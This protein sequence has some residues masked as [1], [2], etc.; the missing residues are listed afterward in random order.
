M[1]NKNKIS[2]IYV[3]LACLLL[4]LI[5]VPI[6]GI[7]L[8]LSGLIAFVAYS[9]FIYFCCKFFRKLNPLLILGFTFL[10]WFL[11]NLPVRLFYWKDALIT[12]WEVLMH[13]LGMITGY[14]LWV[15][16]RIWKFVTLLVAT[17]VCVVYAANNIKW[18]DYLSFGKVD[19]EGEQVLEEDFCLRDLNGSELSLNDFKDKYL[20]LDFWSSSCGLCIKSF[21][22]VQSFSEKFSNNQRVSFYSVFCVSAKRCETRQTGFDIVQKRGFSFPLL[23]SEDE[24]YKKFGV[25]CFPTVVI[26]SPDN[27][28]IFRGRLEIAI[29]FI[30]KNINK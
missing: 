15:N 16:K 13:V 18:L 11:L 7:N 24:S 14:L 25:S 8:E 12:L 21:P 6:R 26:F 29:K 23:F 4:E 19:S 10:A 5:I 9:L 22:E 27:K 28:I 2:Y 1:K 3:F 30:N 17:I 20:V